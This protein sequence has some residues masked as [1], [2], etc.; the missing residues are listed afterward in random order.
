MTATHAKS[1][2]LSVRCGVP[3]V[4]VALG[5]LTWFLCRAGVG[6]EPKDG[7]RVTTQPDEALDAK[8]DV[9][10]VFL[11]QMREGNDL[12]TSVKCIVIH[13]EQVVLNTRVIKQGEVWSHERQ[14]RCTEAEL[15]R[16]IRGLSHAL[17][18]A[19]ADLPQCEDD[20]VEYRIPKKAEWVR[21]KLGLQDRI[22]TGLG[23]VLETQEQPRD[24]KFTTLQEVIEIKI[25]WTDM[26]SAEVRRMSMVELIKKLQANGRVW[27]SIGRFP[28]EKIE[29]RAEEVKPAKG[30]ED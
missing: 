18:V 9:P 13:S 28:L 10:R 23:M 15:N 29:V 24:K 22:A 17:N 20:D 14:L 4:M 27:N 2:F 30:G 5:L 19:A 21:R 7:G 26:P 6:D 1:S 11:L 12:T 25:A 3:V 8:D 16:A